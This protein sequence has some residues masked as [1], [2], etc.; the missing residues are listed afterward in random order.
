MGKLI[1]LSRFRLDLGRNGNNEDFRRNFYEDSEEFSM[2]NNISS[3][4]EFL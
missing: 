3:G 1:G 2:R 4:L